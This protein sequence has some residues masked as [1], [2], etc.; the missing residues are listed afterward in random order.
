M[1]TEKWPGRLRYGLF[2]SILFEG[3]MPNDPSPEY[4]TCFAHPKRNARFTQKKYF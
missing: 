1:R 4:L 2:F 3:P